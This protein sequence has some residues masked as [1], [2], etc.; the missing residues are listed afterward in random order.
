MASR[1]ERSAVAPRVRCQDG[2]GPESRPALPCKGLRVSVALHKSR[3]GRPAW[4]RLLINPSASEPVFE[5]D[6]DLGPARRRSRRARGDGAVAPE[7]GELDQA[8]Q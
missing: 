4:R 8:G 6:P 7:I 3:A 2:G 1:P 5:A